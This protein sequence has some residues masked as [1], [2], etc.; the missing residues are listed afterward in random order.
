MRSQPSSRYSSN[1]LRVFLSYANKLLAL[2]RNRAEESV[3]WDVIRR[4]LFECNENHKHPRAIHSKPTVPPG[5]R[6]IDVNKRCVVEREGFCEYIALS[7]VWGSRSESAC[8]VEQTTCAN[9]ETLKL[10]GGLSQLPE[11]IEDAIT[12][13]QKLGIQYLWVD[14]YCIVQD[15]AIHKHTQLGAM[16]DIYSSS[17]VT[18][19]A[20]SGDGVESG[21]P[22]VR[23]KRQWKRRHINIQGLVFSYLLPNLEE[24]IPKSIWNSRGWT[25]QEAVLS[26]R[27]LLMTPMEV[28]FQCRS[29]TLREYD[30]PGSFNT[31]RVQLR[32]ESHLDIQ[33]VEYTSFR[34]YAVNLAMYTRRNLSYAS[35]IYNAFAGIAQALYPRDDGFHFGLPEPH[36]DQALLWYCCCRWHDSRSRCLRVCPETTPSWSWGSVTCGVLHDE[37]SFCM[38]L[39]K[40]VLYK[41]D[42]THYQEL[43]AMDEPKTWRNLEFGTIFPHLFLALAIKEGCITASEPCTISKHDDNASLKERFT[44]RWPTYADAYKEVQQVDAH[45][46]TRT[47][48]TLFTH[49]QSAVFH[50]ESGLIKNNSGLVIGAVY[51]ARGDESIMY[52]ERSI[53]KGRS[54]YEEDSIGEECNVEGIALSISEVFP[55]RIKHIIR[56]NKRYHPFQRRTAWDVSEEECRDLTY[57]DCNDEP[58]FPFPTVNVMFIISWEDGYARRIGLGWIFLKQWSSFDWTLKDIWLK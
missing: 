50:L 16:A 42:G 40:W 48:G 29:D 9:I 36:F 37:G 14:R 53:P 25:Y 19:I 58:L 18:I 26:E 57:F 13:C 56:L 43:K 2:T 24:I 21:L 46:S 28:W 54:D 1:A 30:S 35:D 23:R 7:Y 51:Q 41:T 4:W 15:H 12:I 10:P 33:G 45:P 17:T 27:K 47:N 31:W 5:F 32:V 34:D 6:L 22:G 20:C 8:Y 55:D 39:V 11:T 38:T 52:E 49:A 3:Q 44:C